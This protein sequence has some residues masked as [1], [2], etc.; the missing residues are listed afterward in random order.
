[1]SFI[2][3]MESYTTL[4]NIIFAFVI[5]IAKLYAIGVGI[6]LLVDVQWIIHQVKTNAEGYQ[7]GDK[8]GD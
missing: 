8:E 3:F 1:M 5:P 6:W 7:N 4:F 2:E